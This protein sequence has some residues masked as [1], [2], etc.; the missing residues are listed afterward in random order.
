M[1]EAAQIQRQQLV[2]Q[3]SLADIQ[4]NVVEAEQGVK[5]AELKAD[6]HIKQATGDAE[7]PHLHFE[8][9]QGPWQAGGHPIDPLPYV[10]QWAAGS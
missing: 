9:W 6:A 5:M 1:Q 3:T 7:G 4:R 8:I 2:R 10:Q